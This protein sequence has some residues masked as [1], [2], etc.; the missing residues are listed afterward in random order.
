MC[1]VALAFTHGS[2][3]VDDVDIYNGFASTFAGLLGAELFKYASHAILRPVAQGLHSVAEHRKRGLATAIH[4]NKLLPVLSMLPWS[5]MVHVQPDPSGNEHVEDE[6]VEVRPFSHT[7]ASTMLMKHFL[8]CPDD[9][10][11]EGQS[12]LSVSDAE[13]ELQ[14]QLHR[15]RRVKVLNSNGE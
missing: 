4:H 13:D 14:P 7:M 9:S 5:S 1:F 15:E 12:S 2:W 3:H 8:I 10:D 11:D 6:H